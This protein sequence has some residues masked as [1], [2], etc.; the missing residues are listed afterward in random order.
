MLRRIARDGGMADSVLVEYR[1]DELGGE[2]RC[3]LGVVVYV[4]IE[5]LSVAVAWGASSNVRQQ[6]MVLIMLRLVDGALCDV[7]TMQGFMVA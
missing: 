1:D 6:A 5:Q 2:M 3:V 4:G 7:I